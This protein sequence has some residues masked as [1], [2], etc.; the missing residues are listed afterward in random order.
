MADR[1]TK[2]VLTII[3]ACLIWNIIAG[4][5]NHDALAQSGQVHVIVDQW[6]AYVATMPISV[7]VQQ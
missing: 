2:V 1:Y 4:S 5:T 7:R 6:G 3:A